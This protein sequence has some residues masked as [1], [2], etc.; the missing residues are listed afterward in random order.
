MK[1]RVLILNLFCLL[2]IPLVSGAQGSV[3]GNVTASAYQ[4]SRADKAVVLV[5]VYWGR[6]WKCS[7]YEN[8]QLRELGFDLSNRVEKNSQDTATIFLEGP[9]LFTDK[10]FTNYAVLIEPGR[11]ALSQ[12][13]IKLAKSISDIKFM[14]AKRAALRAQED[15]TGT[16]DANANETVYIG[17]FAVDCPR[18]EPSLWRFFTTKGTNFEKH[19]TEYKQQ[20]QFLDLT[21]VKHRLFKSNVFANPGEE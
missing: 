21:D 3:S 13:K 14:E 1:T 4:N 7:G 17:N 20:F 2:T 6:R 12:V 9:A 10:D 5:S 15:V 8:A 19:L 18:G 16:F 11:Y